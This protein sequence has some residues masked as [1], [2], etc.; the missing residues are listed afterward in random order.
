MLGKWLNDT[1]A[2]TCIN[3]GHYKIYVELATILPPQFSD[4]NIIGIW[5]IYPWLN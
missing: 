1:C 4:Q 3:Q 2:R 5:S